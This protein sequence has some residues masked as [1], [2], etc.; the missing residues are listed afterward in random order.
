M[1]NTM[2]HHEI[3]TITL[4]EKVIK[5]T[6]EGII[7]SDSF[8]RLFGCMQGLQSSMSDNIK[9]NIKVFQRAKILTKNLRLKNKETGT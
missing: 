4:G 9:D 5:V 6:P 2:T 1:F 8:V 3:K 7:F